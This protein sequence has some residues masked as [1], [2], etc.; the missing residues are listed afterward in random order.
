[1]VVTLGD[2]EVEGAG[3]VG[4][5]LQHDRLDLF[6]G[7]LIDDQ[8]R[9]VERRLPVLGQL[10]GIAALP[11]SPSAEPEATNVTVVVR[12]TVKRDSVSFMSDAKRS[13]LQAPRA[14][15]PPTAKKE[16]AAMGVQTDTDRDKVTVN[17]YDRDPRR[18]YRGSLDID[19]QPMERRQ[20]SSTRYPRSGR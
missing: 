17:R 3:V 5:G 1:M 19:Y 11:G 4:R 12:P 9:D 20:E 6:P 16:S 8:L 7:G 14:G 13:T 10:P 2:A 18:P 15:A